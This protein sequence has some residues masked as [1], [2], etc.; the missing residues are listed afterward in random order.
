[1]INGYTQY[2]GDDYEDGLDEDSWENYEDDYERYPV[3]V[4]R[5]TLWTQLRVWW[6]ELRAKFR[7]TPRD[8]S[9]IPF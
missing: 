6:S 5:A 3:Y 2:E 8:L 4:Q 7:R 1:M 9:D